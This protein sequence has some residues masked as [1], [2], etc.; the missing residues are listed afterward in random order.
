MYSH[1]TKGRLVAE[2]FCLI[3]KNVFFPSGT[4]HRRFSKNE[5]LGALME[6]LATTILSNII[7]NNQPRQRVFLECL[8][9][10]PR[11]MRRFRGVPR[12]KANLT[13]D[14]RARHPK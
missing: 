11:K 7:F 13:V 14:E 8:Q 5:D 4:S 3:K 2:P 1:S 9:E 6:A 12:D 10:T